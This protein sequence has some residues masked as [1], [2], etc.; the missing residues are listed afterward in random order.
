MDI[1][2]LV[3][4]LY[5]GVKNNKAVYTKGDPAHPVN[6]GTLCPKGLSE[7]ETLASSNRYDG[8]MIK[9]DGKLVE[10]S[11]DEAFKKNK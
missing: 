6:M 5:I 10:V 2:G 8:P 3:V 11:W 9:K 1:V 4:V 7:H